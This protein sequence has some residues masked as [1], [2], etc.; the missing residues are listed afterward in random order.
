MKPIKEWSCR[1]EW[2]DKCE[3]HA[4]ALT[5]FQMCSFFIC[6]FFLHFCAQIVWFGLGHCLLLITFNCNSLAATWRRGNLLVCAHRSLA[7]FIRYLY[8]STL[9]HEKTFNNGEKH[10]QFVIKPM[11]SDRISN[12]CAISFHLNK[13]HMKSTFFFF[14][15]AIIVMWGI[16]FLLKVSLAVALFV[17]LFAPLPW[18]TNA[19]I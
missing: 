11:R 6:L 8:I 10:I 5:L 3:E 18:S 9:T 7:T 1:K 2:I 19:H 13:L 12:L 4:T 17:L 15:I 14:I 16:F